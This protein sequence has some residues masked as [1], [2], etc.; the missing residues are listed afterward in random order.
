MC[1][2]VSVAGWNVWTTV[3]ILITEYLGFG[4]GGKCAEKKLLANTKRD[5]RLEHI[6]LASN[7]NFSDKNVD[8]NLKCWF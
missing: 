8:S 6:R 3:W 7:Y 1:V 2:F 4:N 5:G